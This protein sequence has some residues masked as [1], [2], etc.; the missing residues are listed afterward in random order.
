MIIFKLNLEDMRNREG[1]CIQI[2]M[3]IGLPFRV[4]MPPAPI[5]SRTSISLEPHVEGVGVGGC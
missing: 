2:Q 3:V 4:Q 5:F 1:F